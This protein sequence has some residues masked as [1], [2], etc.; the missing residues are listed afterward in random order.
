M[1]LDM[2]SLSIQSKNT[3]C[4]L[5]EYK[6]LKDFFKKVKDIKGLQQVLTHKVS[7]MSVQE[8]CKQLQSD[9]K[10]QGLILCCLSSVMT[11]GHLSRLSQLP[12]HAKKENSTRINETE[13]IQPSKESITVIA[14]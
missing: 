13:A 6:N 9:L 1:C 5:S 7:S 3:I 4:L 12:F 14:K 2:K 10:S 11:S 8:N